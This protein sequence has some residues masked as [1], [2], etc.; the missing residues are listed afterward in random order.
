MVCNSF[1]HIQGEGCVLLPFTE[2]SL[3][4]F[5]NPDVYT[6][7]GHSDVTYYENVCNSDAKCFKAS[8]GMTLMG[9]ADYYETGLNSA[10]EC[11][12]LCSTHWYKCSSCLFY[13]NGGWCILNADNKDTVPDRFEPQSGA[14][15]F[16]R[17]Q[18]GDINECQDSPL[19]LVFVVDGSGSIG[20]RHFNQMKDYLSSV[21]DSLNVA[22]TRVGVVQFSNRV[23]T[24]IYLND[25]SDKDELKDAISGITWMKG[26]TYIGKAL[27]YTDDEVL[28]QR[29]GMREHASQV[30]VLFTDGYSADDGATPAEALRSQ[31][32]QVFVVGITNGVDE[33]QL[34][35]IAGGSENVIVVD[36]FDKLN[37]ELTQRLAGK[38]CGGHWIGLSRYDEEYEW[39]DGSTLSFENFAFKASL[40]S[41]CVFQGPDGTWVDQSCTKKRSFVCKRPDI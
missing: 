13:K 10:E 37:R 20:Q 23:Q 11:Q 25:Y 24:E 7:S 36:D 16:D 33:S 3:S 27:E 5:N 31:G 4:E 34:E 19:D 22:T 41:D 39:E 15:Y 29:H 1:L 28:T 38:M 32:I 8:P 2:Q 21:V 40:N 17:V 12:D 26:S 9:L 14:E 35:R 6:E 18:C 30:V